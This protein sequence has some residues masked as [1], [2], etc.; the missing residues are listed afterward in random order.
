[1][2]V[3]IDGAPTH[4]LVV[5]AVAVFL[6]LAILAALMLVAFPVTRRAFGL[7]SVAVA[8][9][10]CVAVPLAFASGSALRGQLP[11]SPLIDRHVRLAHELLPLA[12]I[13]GLSLAGFV[14][15][16]LLRRSRRDEVNQ[17]EAIAMHRLSRLRDYARRH[18]LYAAHRVAA[19]LLV[20]TALATL[21]TVVRVGDSGA[22][23]AWHGRLGSVVN[24]R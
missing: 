22:N 24:R 19:V 23:A 18:R 12:A 7:L 14:L 5:H 10:G 6:P 17:I 15:I 2:P 16:D 21:V 1:M 3:T 13:F 20:L 11:V 9:I 4:V 8:F